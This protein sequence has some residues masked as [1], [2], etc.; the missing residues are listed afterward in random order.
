MGKVG[1]YVKRIKEGRLREMLLQTKWIYSYGKVYWKQMIIYTLLGLSGTVLALVASWFS[2]DLVDIITGHETG[3]V[4]RTFCTMIG[5]TLVNNFISQISGYVSTKINMQVDSKIKQDIFEKILITDWESLTQY[6]TGDLLARWSSDVSTI[7]SGI[8]SYVPNLI[9]SFFR[10]VSALVVMLQNDWSFAVIA[11]VGMPLSFLISKFSLKKMKEN[12]K[13]SKEINANMSGFNQEAFSNVQTIKAFSL[14]PNYVKRLS[15]LQKEYIEMTLKYKRTQIVISLIMVLLGMIVGYASYGW[16]IYRVWSGSI[17]YGS[18]TMLLSLSSTLTN[19]LDS[20]LSFVPTAVGL[21]TSAGRL[22]DI[23]EMEREDYSNAPEVEEFGKK[24][25]NTGIALNIRNIDY[26][27]RSGTEV[28]AGASIYA[29]P[30][31]VVALVGP[32]GEG[33]TTMLRIILSLV[34]SKGGGSYLKGGKLTDE[35]ISSKAEE[36]M[37]KYGLVPVVAQETSEQNDKE[38]TAELDTAEQKAAEENASIE[39]VEVRTRIPLNAA[40]RALFSYV[41]QG[42][43]MF[44]G[45]IAYNMRIVKPDATD[46]EIWNALEMACAKDFVE[47]LPNRLDTELQERG[48]GLSEG[49]SQRLSIARAIL[50]KSPLLLLDE[51]TSALDVATERKLLKNIMQD[52]YPRTCIVTTHRPTVLSVCKRVYAIRDKQCEVLNDEEINEMVRGF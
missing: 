34:R 25:A 37:Q 22:M 43:T 4:I 44:S 3:A 13:K 7:S 29:N 16:G 47:K 1:F 46:E 2:K 8:L 10:F 50:R 12:D 19:S 33:K 49:Q 5:I 24:Y 26:T 30:H 51:A 36:L 20:L 32:S 28:F 27:Y 11:F 21:T 6:H 31:E 23:V 15:T 39:K 14:V 40:S 38:N 45:S 48:G 35:D 18:M 52:D 9:I 42:N 41:P 17:T